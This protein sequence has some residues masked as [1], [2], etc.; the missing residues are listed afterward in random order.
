VTE[1]IRAEQT[2][3][4]LPILEA[5]RLTKRFRSGGHFGQAH[6]VTAVDDVSLTIARGEAFGLVGESGSG[7]TTLGRMLLRLEE[8]SEGAILFEGQDITHRRGGELRRL[9]PSMQIVFQDPFTALNPWM[10]VSQ[11]IGEPLQVHR[12][13]GG[14]SLTAEVAR[15]LDL[16]GL[17]AAAASRRPKEFSGG[18]RQRICLARALA[19]QPKLLVL[20][21][22]TS[23]LDVSVQA[24]ILNLLQNLR[25]EMGLTYIFVSHDLAVVGYLCDRVGVMRRGRLLEVLSRDTFVTVPGHAYTRALRDAL[26]EIGRPLDVTEVVA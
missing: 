11:A 7:K 22:P 1:R 16:V 19:L 6:V 25:R 14:S 17:P 23:A 4:A 3:T 26:P 24:Q 2:G 12:G 15:L 8:P 9:R 20:D 5:R 18:Q 21:E 13:L 10:T